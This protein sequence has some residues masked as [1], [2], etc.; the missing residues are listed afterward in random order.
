MRHPRTVAVL[1]A[2][3]IVLTACSAGGGGSLLSQGP[4]P[5]AAPSPLPPIAA[6][7][8]RIVEVVERVTPAVVNVRA[9]VGAPGRQPEGTGFVIG[10]DGIVVTNFHVVEQ[11]FRGV[12]VIMGDGRRFQA[13]A[14]GA[15]DNADLAILKLQSDEPLNLPT[16]ALGDSDTLRLGQTVVAMG[17]ALGLQGGPSVT[18]GIVSALGRTIQ[19]GDN[20]QVRTYEDLIQTDA[21]INPGN[22][23]G[24]LLDL[25]GQVVGINTAGASQAENIGFAISINRA[26]PIIDHAIED[27]DA[28]TPLLGV[29]TQTVDPLVVAE[30]G[31][32]VDRGVVVLD[33]LPGGPADDARIR[34]GDVIVGIDGEDVEDN[35]ELQERLL[36]HEPGKEVSV[37]LVRSD[38]SEEDVTVTLDVRPVPAG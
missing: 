19:A 32:P 7:S 13:R 10:S 20:G 38:G 36:D 16:V 29:V 1:T 31:L 9:D 22:S 27:P 26:R 35:D 33:V 6:G 8:N 3:L 17:F 24:P 25:D 34:T 23:G 28:P 11:A 15:D 30:L 2:A 21:A 5:T 12:D 18:S 14:I 4:E 37:Q